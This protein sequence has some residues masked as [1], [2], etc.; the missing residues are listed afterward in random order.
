MWWAVW[1][2]AVAA[3]GALATGAP[4][5]GALAPLSPVDWEQIDVSATDDENVGNVLAQPEGR[6]AAVSPWV[7]LLADMPRDSQGESGRV[8]RR[9]PTLSIDLPMSVLRHK[10]SLEQERKAQALRAVEN[11]NFLNG[12]GKRGLRWSPSDEERF[13]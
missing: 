8:K 6:Y 11:R 9:M 12:I 4:S 3:T 5:V 1:C 2:V 13:Y 7:Y 10:L